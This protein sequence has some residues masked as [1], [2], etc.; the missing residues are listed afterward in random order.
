MT[1]SL[2]IGGEALDTGE[3]MEG[4]D[5]LVDDC[6]PAGPALFMEAR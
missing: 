2:F 1:T 3:T 4:V 5:E 6:D